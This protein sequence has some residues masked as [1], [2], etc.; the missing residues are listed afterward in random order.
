MLATQLF[1]FGRDSV[2][3][4][5]NERMIKLMNY[6]GVYRTA[7]ATPGQLCRQSGGLHLEAFKNCI[8]GSKSTAVMLD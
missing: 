7:P 3:K 5:L 6:K 4:I 2:L 8:I 1:R